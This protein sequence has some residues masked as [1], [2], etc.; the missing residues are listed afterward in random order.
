MISKFIVEEG[1]QKG[2]MFS[3]TEGDI[4]VIGSDP[5]ECQFIVE[6]PSI[7][8]KQAIVRR[9][10]EGVTLEN[11]NTE[12]PIYVNNNIQI[13]AHLLEDGDVIKMGDVTF[14]YYEQED[15]VERDEEKEVE[16]EEEEE[17]ES[18]I[19]QEK[20][21]APES[22][23]AS[24]DFGL[25][26]T[27]RWLLKVVGGPNNGAEFQMETAREYVL[28]T[29]PQASDII[30]QDTSVSRQHARISIAEDD[31][32][33]IEDLKSRNGT[34]IGNNRITGKQALPPSAMVTI[35]TTTFVVYDREGDMQTIISPLM[36]SI[37][38]ALQQEESDK[39]KERENEAALAASQKE[40]EK[41]EKASKE[42]AKEVPKELPKMKALETTSIAIIAAVIGLF[43]LTLYGTYNLFRNEPIVHVQEENPENAIQQV[44]LSYPG[45]YYTFN[46]DN[47]ALVLSGHLLT[48][49]DKQDLM[50]ELRSL[51]WVKSV[52]D[53]G[54]I[55]DEFILQEVNSILA[56]HPAWK[57]IRVLST[58][59]GHF[60]MTGFLNTR[61]Q[62]EAL[63]NYM[64]INF[65]H[66]ELLEKRVIVEEDVLKNVNILIQD[67][68]LKGVNAQLSNGELVFTGTIPADKQSTFVE[69]IEKSKL[70]PGVR[71]TRNN[72]KTVA[73]MDVGIVDLTA[74]Y[75]VTGHSRLE[76]NKHSV[77]IDGRILQERD[78]LDGM[79]ITKITSSS[80]FLQKGENQYRINYKP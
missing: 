28:G 49:G 4:W 32:L 29:D 27:G 33:T 45:V 34:F 26:E 16:P 72:V 62:A 65:P 37:V 15:V 61:Q 60:V 18:S 6:D 17:E 50:G 75:D 25:E 14:N 79:T 24:I 30:F 5:L 73:A 66:P 69:V 44:M 10:P 20:I 77:V 76:D 2:L 74:R 71:I 40:S 21:E 3:L 38:R 57:D 12:N 59:A 8:P 31:T 64:Q 23:L 22:Q 63:D 54:I 1:T 51:K 7:D 36:P 35:G 19:F 42:A 13:G 58:T 41:S 52:N 55:I 9:S 68:H 67:S 48:V 70:I 56:N 46:R 80:I 43:A 78:Q 39:K 53:T 11:I 47:G